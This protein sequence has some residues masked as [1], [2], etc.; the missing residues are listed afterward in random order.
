VRTES[1]LSTSPWSVALLQHAHGAGSPSIQWKS[2]RWVRKSHPSALP[3]PI[4]SAASTLLAIWVAITT[5]PATR[6]G[7]MPA[8]RYCYRRLRRQV[9]VPSNCPLLV[10]PAWCDFCGNLG[11]SDDTQNSVPYFQAHQPSS[12]CPNAAEVSAAMDV[13]PEAP[14]VP[15]LRAAVART[16]RQNPNNKF[17]YLGKRIRTRGCRQ[18]NTAGG[19][20]FWCRDPDYVQPFSM[21]SPGQRREGCDGAL[22]EVDSSQEWCRRA[23]RLSTRKKLAL[24]PSGVAI[25]RSISLRQ[26]KS[27]Q[28]FR[29]L[30]VRAAD[31]STC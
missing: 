14:L 28:H 8:L 13:A 27:G 15:Q 31:T 20:R 11:M 23:S 9:A 12:S 18:R 2:E 3:R 1:H 26:F 24:K 30:P 5:S 19:S 22:L 7:N 29:T 10:I 25:T 21:Q 17:A 4:V 16:T 6:W